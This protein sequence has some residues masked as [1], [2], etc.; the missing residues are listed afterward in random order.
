M[1]WTI[2][3]LPIVLLFFVSCESDNIE[4]LFKETGCNTENIR[5]SSDVLPILNTHCMSCHNSLA[6]LGGVVLESY[7]EVLFWV[8]NERLL[9]SIKHLPGFSPMPQAG[10]KLDDCTIEKIEAWIQ[11]GAPDN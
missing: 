11:E 5:F 6:Q 7:E 10:L 4:D 1:K 2:L 3:L 9:G 8:N